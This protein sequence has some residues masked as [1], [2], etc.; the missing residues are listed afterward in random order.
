MKVRKILPVL[1]LIL[2]AVI[3]LSIKPCNNSSLP[4]VLTE[5]KLSANSTVNTGK[6]VNLIAQ[7]QMCFLRNMPDAE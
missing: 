1:L 3:T 7:L 5:K 4:P 2:M 6:R